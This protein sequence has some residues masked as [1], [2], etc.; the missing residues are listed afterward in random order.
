MITGTCCVGC[1][2]ASILGFI[3]VNILG[4]LGT[5]ALGCLGT[6]ASIGTICITRGGELLSANINSIIL[7]VEKGLRN[8]FDLI[9]L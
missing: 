7:L 5:S 2:G 6:G 1:T 3:G 4:C 9:G 8:C